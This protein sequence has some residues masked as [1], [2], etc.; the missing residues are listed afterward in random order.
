MGNFGTKVGTN[1]ETDSDKDL[2][3]TTKYGGLKVFMSGNAQFTTDGSK[4]GSVTIP[5][6]L[7]YAPMTLVLRKHTAQFT[8]LSGAT[9]YPNAFSYLGAVN[10][11]A[12]GNVN[13]SFQVRT[14]TADLVIE[15]NS[16]ANNLAADT[17][18]YFRYYILVDLSQAFSG[19]FGG[20]LGDNYGFKVALPGIDVRT[21]KEYELAYSSKYK[22][23][24]YFD[25][26]VQEQEL[27]L[28]LISAN[29]Y[30]TFEAEGTYVDFEHDLGY[31]P[32]YLAY[33]TNPDGSYT[34]LPFYAENGID[35]INFN[36]ACF[37]DASRVRA[38]VWR[39]ANLATV[40][41]VT[42]ESHAEMTTTIRCLIFTENL[43]GT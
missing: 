38:F 32:L 28:P 22:S 16:V 33:Y 31:P 43:L 20:G 17:T 26:Y 41:P 36:V 12:G 13:V 9:T 35:I 19:D 40:V 34:P 25:E 7:G 8:F 18:Y 39:S 1:V 37:S 11:Y 30:D 14:T 3:F 15:N 27:T 42:Y 24:Q 29:K 23:L 5:H 10:Y 2:K 6:N 21:A 4:E